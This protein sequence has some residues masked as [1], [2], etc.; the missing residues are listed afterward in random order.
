MSE[1]ELFD[2]KEVKGTCTFPMFGAGFYFLSNSKNVNDKGKK[3]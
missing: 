1:L 3:D 2:G